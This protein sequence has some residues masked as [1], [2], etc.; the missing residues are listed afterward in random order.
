MAKNDKKRSQPI[1]A[2]L[3]SNPYAAPQTAES[4][5]PDVRKAF[6]IIGLV[7]S[8]I[9]I[10]I[11]SIILVLYTLLMAFLADCGSLSHGGSS[12]RPRSDG[13]WSSMT[14]LFW[15]LFATALCAS[16]W[17]IYSLARNRRR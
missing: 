15:V 8:L 17:L 9:V 12:S 14:T 7:L 13:S 11:L 4:R 3:T 10:S 5:G 16:I 1:T 6:K 2:N